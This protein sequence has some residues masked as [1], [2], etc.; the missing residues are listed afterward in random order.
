MARLE[1]AR[2]LMLSLLLCACSDGGDDHGVTPP[3]DA[4]IAPIDA[5]L[6]HI[7]AALV[8]VDASAALSDGGTVPADASTDTV[9][10]QACD[11][12]AGG[13]CPE[14]Y[15]CTLYDPPFAAPQKACV[16]RIGDDALG[17]SCRRM[18]DVA[19]VDSCAPGLDCVDGFDV[20]ESFCVGPRQCAAGEACFAVDRDVGLC[21]A[22]G[23]D[24]FD[25]DA[26][27]PG[28]TCGLGTSRT[29]DATSPW[30]LATR[31]YESVGLLEGERCHVLAHECAPTLEC[32][33]T[34][35]SPGTYFCRR[36]CSA[37]HP[38]ATGECRYVWGGYV[39]ACL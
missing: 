35:S 39:G 3:I 31:C 17:A 28:F 11:Y 20:C 10:F 8:H 32:T 9:I 33:F 27:G 14:G 23:C 5:A 36:L 29:G 18:P 38:C 24:R 2:H 16:R 19:S 12:W 13:T 30:D 37:T 1:S 21:H 7:D 25:A 6:A 22:A 15:K 26:C 34:P 4:S